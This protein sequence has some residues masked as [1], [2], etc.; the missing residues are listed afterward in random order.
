LQSLQVLAVVLQ[1][2]RF[3]DEHEWG[4]LHSTEFTAVETALITLLTTM[5]SF[6]A[7]ADV[8]VLSVLLDRSDAD[9]GWT[10]AVV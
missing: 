1:G 3:R 2:R 4:T 7:K 5:G 6:M 9:I 10:E 8:K